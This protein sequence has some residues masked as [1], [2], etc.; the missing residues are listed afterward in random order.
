MSSF[1][2]HRVCTVVILVLASL[3]AGLLTG[4]G[5]V[6]LGGEPL[7]AVQAGGAVLAGC[8]GICMSAAAYMS[9]QDS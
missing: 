3:V 4:I 9:R 7:A 1:P 6:L 2:H 5:W 8:F